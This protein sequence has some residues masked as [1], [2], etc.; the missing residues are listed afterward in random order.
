MHGLRSKTSP[1]GY[2]VS[3]SYGSSMCKTE[4]EYPRVPFPNAS[5]ER[6]TLWWCECLAL[7]GCLKMLLVI[8]G[9]LDEAVRQPAQRRERHQGPQVVRVNGLDR[10]VPE[11]DRGAVHPPLQ[12]PGRHE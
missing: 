2:S 11:E 1:E 9:G 8:A 3:L 5:L 12:R 10:G 6:T 7:G 4:M